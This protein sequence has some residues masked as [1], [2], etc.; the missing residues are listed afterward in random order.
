MDE[1][2]AYKRQRDQELEQDYE[3]E[4][5]AS[6]L[7][8]WVQELMWVRR[9]EH[10]VVIEFSEKLPDTND[11]IPT[12]PRKRKAASAKATNKSNDTSIISQMDRKEN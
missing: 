11:F 9:N 5:E 6:K 1:L 2:D 7:G 8:L 3:K 4:R 12:F 10:G